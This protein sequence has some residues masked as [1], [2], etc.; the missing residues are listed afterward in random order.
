[1]GEVVKSKR[2]FSSLVRMPYQDAIAVILR[3]HDYHMSMA[4]MG[5]NSEFHKLQAERLK[6]WLVDV[7]DYITKLEKE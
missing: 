1:V 6:N 2:T 4:L 5:E 3:C 7:K